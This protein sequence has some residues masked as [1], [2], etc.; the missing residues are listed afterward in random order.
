MKLKSLHELLNKYSGSS[1]KTQ[2]GERIYIKN[3]N[4]KVYKVIQTCEMNPFSKNNSYTE[5]MGSPRQ[6][7]ARNISY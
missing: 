6:A 3:K 5:K 2:R 4:E 7:K 1:S